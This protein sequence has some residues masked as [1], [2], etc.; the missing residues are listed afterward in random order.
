[1]KN[2]KEIQIQLRLVIEGIDIYFTLV[3]S[4]ETF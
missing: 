4:Y 2:V 3:I 1:M